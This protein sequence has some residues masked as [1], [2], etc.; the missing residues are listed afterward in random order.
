MF[1]IQSSV[2]ALRTETGCPHWADQT[3]HSSCVDGTTHFGTPRKKRNQ[4]R[5]YFERS[6][7]VNQSKSSPRISKAHHK[8][9]DVFF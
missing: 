8:R 6:K 1:V 5:S 4:F 2:G 3:S 9:E 7:S